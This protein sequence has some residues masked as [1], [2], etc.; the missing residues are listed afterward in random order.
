[1]QTHRHRLPYQRAQL[2]PGVCRAFGVEKIY[3]DQDLRLNCLEGW[4]RHE[5]A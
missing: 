2:A 4:I 1:M 5:R 3:V